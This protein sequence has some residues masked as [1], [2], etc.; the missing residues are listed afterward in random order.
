M[1]TLAGG[2]FGPGK[3][4]AQPGKTSPDVPRIVIVGAGFGGLAAARALSRAP[5]AITIIDRRN[6]HLFQPLLYQ[7]ATAGLSPAD[8]AYPIRAIIGMNRNTEVV[9]DEVVSVDLGART[10]TTSHGAI[11]YDF[12]VLAPGAAN[13]YFGRDEWENFAPGLKSLEDAL[14]IR[15]RIL[16][17]FEHAER[18][19][20]SVL[21]R[22]LLT[23]VV[24]G[25][26]PTGVELAGAIAEISRHVIVSDFRRI[27]PREARV[28][29]VEAG[30]RI[31]PSFDEKLAAKAE[32][33]LRG[34]GVEIMLESPVEAIAP[35][36][37][38]TARA[39]LA[40]HTVIWAA[41]VR[42]S[43]LGREL[44]VELDRAGRVKVG[45]GL[46]LAGHPEVFVIGDLASCPD[47]NGRP[48]PG[49]A[50]VAMQQGRHAA[51]NIMR[52]LK[53]QPNK[54]FRYVDKGTM[55]TVG[56]AFAI[57]RIGR[58]RLSGFLGWLAWSFVHI[59]YLIGFRSRAIV[60]FEWA[61]AYFTYQRGARLITG[62]ARDIR[63]DEESAGG[64]LKG[65]AE[66]KA[67]GGQT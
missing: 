26:G 29:L 34:R 15:R 47:Q 35:A 49:L 33:A 51:R 54:R 46:A 48:L 45:P 28:V 6:H 14:E 40:A 52:A 57:A 2:F 65:R 53:N 61:W 56:R 31:L 27:D 55:T 44:G 24:V 17:A 19:S 4:C 21:R 5:A 63:Y 8:I 25:A 60:M 41:G 32:R 13:S 66:Q 64:S 12:L 59:A 10:V 7:V 36:R 37:V 23:F 1:L 38:E 11:R 30:A 20:D 16:L 39:A 18:A 62:G 43:R 58:L 42:A 67:P 50:P 9:L 22:A 3:R